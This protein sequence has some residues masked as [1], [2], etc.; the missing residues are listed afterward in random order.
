MT[1]IF[2][3]LAADPRRGNAFGAYLHGQHPQESISSSWCSTPGARS[4]EESARQSYIE[5]QRKNP[6]RAIVELTWKPAS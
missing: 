2:P 5:N 3:T 1:Q 4:A 6:N